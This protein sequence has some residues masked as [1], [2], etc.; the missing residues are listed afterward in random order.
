MLYNFI[1]VI[2]NGLWPIEFGSGTLDCTIQ[3]ETLNFPIY[4]TFYFLSNFPGNKITN[5][6]KGKVS[7]TCNA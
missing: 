1:D 3:Q 4:P 7:Y 2:S 5:V 6:I